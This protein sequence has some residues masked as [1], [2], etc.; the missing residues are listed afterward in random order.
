[1]IEYP[2]ALNNENIIVKIDD[3]TVAYK[4]QH[5][6]T[7]PNCNKEMIAKIKGEARSPHFAHNN[8]LCSK[9]TYWHKTAKFLFEKRFKWHMSNAIPIS[10]NYKQPEKCNQNRCHYGK[11][12]ICWKK[13]I[14]TFE[15]LPKFT[16]CLVEQT[17]LETGLRPDVTLSNNEKEKLYVEIF[18]S[19]KSSEEKKATLI[20]IIE[21]T[22]KNQFDLDEVFGTNENEHLLNLNNNLVVTHNII[23]EPILVTPYC[24]E[25][26]KNAKAAFKKFFD[27]QI[28]NGLSI[29]ISC[30]GDCEDKCP[31]FQNGICS[32]NDKTIKYPLSQWFNK[33]EDRT[34]DFNLYLEN[35]N[36][37]IQFNFAME[38]FKEGSFAKNERIIQFKINFNNS[39]YPWETQ[40]TISESN[41][42]HF[43]GIHSKAR[44]DSQTWMKKNF[45][46]FYEQS[47]TQEH[48]II[49]RHRCNGKCSRE[50][51]YFLNQR[52]ESESNWTSFP[53]TKFFKKIGSSSTCV[54]GFAT[55]FC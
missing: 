40:T 21:I 50:C 39:E 2:Y 14:K 47:I 44:L 54:G 36:K 24:I 37:K 30:N 26:L 9:E 15:L 22:I 43:F 31:N 28:N 25:P 20:P 33:I 12:S 23:K 55:L 3:V 46:R 1:M 49:M 38:L 16:K 19:H 51:P 42:V 11:N 8:Q 34:D 48:E 13:P 29:G 5:T 18:H 52:C 41:T 45:K 4:K 17:D 53:I 27:N 7:C 10:I 6:F 35:G 32:S